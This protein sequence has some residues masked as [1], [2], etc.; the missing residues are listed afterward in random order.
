M[1]IKSLTINVNSN[2]TESVTK[3]KKCLTILLPSFT[4]KSLNIE[5]LVGGYSNTITK[6]EYK[7][8]DIEKNLLDVQNIVDRLSP[9]YKIQIMDELEKRIDKK[10]VLHLRFGKR[11]LFNGKIVLSS[12]SD[13]V[14]IKLKIT[15][16]KHKIDI[17]K[18]IRELKEFLSGL[19]TIES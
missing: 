4:D 10:G 1:E 18:N 8:I 2:A 3:V 13:S 16:E 7:S 15:H 14:R 11:D 17:K 6:M 12:E 5:A 19:G 9:Q